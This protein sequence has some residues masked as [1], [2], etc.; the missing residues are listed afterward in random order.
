[1]SAELEGVDAAPSCLRLSPKARARRKRRLRA[2]IADI[3]K[4]ML[5]I[6]ELYNHQD[7]EF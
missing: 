6:N 4:D 1:M 7:D 2:L 5:Q 3:L